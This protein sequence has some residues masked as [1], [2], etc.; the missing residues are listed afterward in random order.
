VIGRLVGEVIGHGDDGT[1]TIDVN[2]VGYE[3]TVPLGALGRAIKDGAR[4]T[5]HIHTV[6]REDAFQLYGFP[7]L[8]EREVFRI[9]IAVSNVGPK[10][11]TSILGAM[12]PAELQ[13][14]IARRELARLTAISGVGRKTAERLLLELKDK[15]G[16]LTL[17]GAPPPAINS[18]QPA[19][20]A[21]KQE[22]LR[23]ALTN[24]GFKPLEVDRAIDAVRDRIATGELAE[25]VRDALASAAR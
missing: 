10:I 1:I 15:L 20:V 24:M 18:K 6:V 4:T 9:L 3:V 14:A 12:P 22:L 21:T 23:S 19:P 8:E 13:S 17:A 25:L 2:G 7:S 11:A 16:G 5:L